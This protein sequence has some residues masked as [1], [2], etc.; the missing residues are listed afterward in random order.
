MLPVE[1]NHTQPHP[2]HAHQHQ[3]Q[4]QEHQQQQHPQHG[5]HPVQQQQLNGHH[6]LPS[7]Q[8][9][10]PGFPAQLGYTEMQQEEDQPTKKQQ[11][12]EAPITKNKL[13][14][15]ENGQVRVG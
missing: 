11:Q 7:L 15:E 8:P 3:H 5:P 9:G 2:G 13:Y 6:A 4:Q 14:T 12:E 10:Q 1:G